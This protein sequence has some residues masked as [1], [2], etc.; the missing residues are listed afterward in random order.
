MSRC[1]RIVTGPIIVCFFILVVAVL[2]QETETPDPNEMRVDGDLIKARIEWLARDETEGRQSMTEAFRKTTDWVANEFKKWG[3]EPAGE[4]ATYFQEVPIGSR[5]DPERE[6][7]HPYGRPSF[8]IGGQKY[9]L[10]EGDFIPHASS[11]AA[12]SVHAEVVFAGYGISA[13]DEGLDEYAD[14]NVADK[15][16]LIIKG[17]PSDVSTEEKKNEGAVDPWKD[18]VSD[19]TKIETA[20]DQGASAVLLYEP[21][22]TEARA[23]RSWSYWGRSRD[24]DLA[25]ERD[26]LWLKVSDRILHGII[27]TDPQE[28]VRGFERRF[29]GIQEDIQQK[30]PRSMD[31][32]VKVRIKGYDRIEIF[33][34]K[35]DNNT[36]RNVL[37]KIPGTDPKLKREYVIMGA[38]L[39]HV[40]IRNGLVYNGADDNASGSAVVMELARILSK[41]KYQP[42]RTIIFACWCGEELGLIG[43]RHY[44]K[45][46]CNDV[47]MDRV[48]TYFNMDMVGLGDTIGAPGALNFPSIWKVI[49]R[50]QDE[51]VMAV[52]E[53]RTGGPGGSD[54]AP[55]IE[56]GIEALALMTGSDFRGDH[57]DYH[58][59]EDDTHK[60]DP[61]ILRK[62][63]EFVLQGTLNVAQE[64][65][66]NLIIENRK[67]LYEGMR[68]RMDNINPELKDSNWRYVGIAGLSQEQLRGRIASAKQNKGK[69]LEQG[70]KDLSV[71]AGDVELLLAASD[72]FGFGRVDIK[73][74]DGHWVKQGRLTREGRYAL[75]MLQTK[76][77]AVNLVSPSPRLMGSMLKNAIRP[78]LITGFYR[79]SQQ[80]YDRLKAKGAVLGVEF[81]PKDVESCV[82]QL[83]RAKAGLG[84]SEN[85]LLYV[86]G[87]ADLD[88]AKQALYVSLIKKGWKAEEIG[89]S[90]I[91]RRR[92]SASGIAG[93]NLNV[94]R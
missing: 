60:I 94:L 2:A 71:F 1:M 13:Q 3:L 85:L 8:Q 46:P 7:I 19:R 52:V 67:A 41:A 31:T 74:S 54:F 30:K 33:S 75:D 56:L 32:G 87:T 43:S 22:P 28:S 78:F 5:W 53:P 11:T 9:L 39:D 37:A 65:K 86:T 77:I 57:P 82:T 47:S 69:S 45:W 34:K 29:K 26:F 49:T 64:T 38:H 79:P 59:P 80:L 17:S 20:Y 44:V 62:T 72:A 90:R 88:K 4:G 58:Q 25:F 50:D 70:V 21:T 92:G 40:G 91:S 18:Y 48:V 83:Q 89:S 76:G 24:K 55:F 15:V 16:V 36:A 27:K 68:L 12:T 93:G 10:Q 61:E 73:G 84:S 35:L 51:D 42:K 23:R 63:G 6:Y 66:V 81:N 14:V